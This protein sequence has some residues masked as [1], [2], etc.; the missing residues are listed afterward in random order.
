MRFTPAGA[1]NRPGRSITVCGQVDEDT[2][3]AISVPPVRW[4]PRMTR[5]SSMAAPRLTPMRYNLGAVAR[6]SE[7]RRLRRP[8]LFEDL[9]SMRRSPISRRSSPPRARRTSRAA[10]MPASRSKQ[11]EKTGRDTRTPRRAWATR[12]SM[13]AALFGHPQHRC[14]RRRALFAGPRPDRAA[15]QRQRQAGQPGRLCRDPVPLLIADD[16]SVTRDPANRGV[17]LCLHR[18]EPP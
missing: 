8:R 7:L 2:A 1:A 14:Y 5:K 13:S 12:R 11:N 16:S 4:P 15:H 10:S 18:A 17:F 6:L 9:S 3:R